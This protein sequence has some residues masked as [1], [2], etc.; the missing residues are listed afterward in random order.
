MTTPP[1]GHATN[2]L[3]A[4]RS[5]YLL[6]HAHNPVDWHPWGEAALRLAREQDRP[7]LLSIGYSAC[8][9]CHVMAHESFEDPA[10][11][12]LM[13]TLFVNI[14]VDREERPDLDRIYQLAHQMLTGRGGGWPLTVFMTPDQ[15]PFFAGTYFP[16][17]ARYGLPAFADLLGRVDEYYR[18]HR[19]DIDTQNTQLLE[20]LA[21]TQALGGDAAPTD[22]P[23]RRATAEL[24][25][26]FDGTHGGFGGA[27]KF[28]QAPLLERCLREHARTGD[29]DA[30]RMALLTLE[31]MARGGIHDHLGGGFF[32]YAVD[33]EWTIPHFEKMLYDNAQLLRLYAQAAQISASPRFDAILHTTGQWALREMRAPDGGFYAALDADSEGEEGRFYAWD[34]REVQGLL[35]EEEYAVL[36]R[37]FGLDDT[38]NFEGHWHLRVVADVADI[39]EEIDLSPQR[40]AVV[41][42]GAMQKLF[43]ARSG[44]VRPGLDDKILAGWN[45]LM[46][47]GLAQAG[48]HLNEPA[49]IDAAATAA[50]FARRVLW[51]DGRLHAAA[52]D[53]VGYL[54]AYLD[55]HAYLLDGLLELLQARWNGAHLAFAVDLAEVMLTHFEDRAH[56]GFFH[57]ADD[58][59]A[60]IV[61][62]RP[63]GDDATPAGT[64]LAARALG[65][66]GHLLGEVRYIDAAARAVHSASGRLQEH[67]LG[68][69]SLLTALEEQLTP[70]QTLVLRGDAAALAPWLAAAR[71]GY[72]PLRLTLAVPPD[73]ADLP[74]VLAH[75]RPQGD[76]VAY[77]CQGGQCGAP[78]TQLDA[79]TAALA[80]PA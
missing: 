33:G 47:G 39:A 20:A 69:C 61:R 30:L 57:T 23:L 12:A 45:G 50:D 36:A 8:H 77:L 10:T 16:K 53:G 56:G 4:E 44:R 42:S 35:G 28:P 21:D 68:F 32:R 2:R 65:R 67:P 6:Q 48:R 58:H 73:A 1:T 37:R 40:V 26:L 72:R 43:T 80:E 71:A 15:V 31:Q 76:A 9:W 52:K 66:L 29:Q 49:F 3:A 38:P 54:A 19:A 79:F 51:Q 74:G 7:I 75:C 24:K 63:L 62:T 34:R 70:P 18:E 14:K 59:E 46:I 22:A 78:L 13:N 17:A 41:L 60:L 5:P 64:A 11:A 25:R 55:D 27:P